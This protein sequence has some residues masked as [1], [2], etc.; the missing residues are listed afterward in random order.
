MFKRIILQNIFSSKIDSNLLMET[1]DVYLK[2][3][4]MFGDTSTVK[5][6]KNNRIS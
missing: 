6:L 4:K 5:V 3:G 1:I 2:L